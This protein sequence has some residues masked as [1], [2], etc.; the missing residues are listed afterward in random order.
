MSSVEKIQ[1]TRQRLLADKPGQPLWRDACEEG[2]AFVGDI[3]FPSPLAGES[4]RS[5][6]AGLPARRRVAAVRRGDG[7]AADLL[8]RLAR[9]LIE[10]LLSF[11]EG[12]VRPV[13]R[14]RLD[15]AKPLRDVRGNPQAKCVELE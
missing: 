9:L 15:I 2:E 12:R 4:Q 3:V 7:P 11:A 6:R 1:A 5:P 10:S 8:G 13:H 14:K